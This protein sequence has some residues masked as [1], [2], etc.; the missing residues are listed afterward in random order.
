MAERGNQ[1]VAAEEILNCYNLEL[2]RR[3]C[4]KYIKRIPNIPNRDRQYLGGGAGESWPKVF[5]LRSRNQHFRNGIGEGMGNLRSGSVELLR[6]VQKIA[7]QPTKSTL[8]NR[9]Q[10]WTGPGKAR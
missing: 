1:S 9:L 3:F 5:P 7:E 10:N 4:T 6:H 2:A 8:V